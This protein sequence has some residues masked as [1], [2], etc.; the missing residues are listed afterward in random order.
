MIVTVWTVILLPI[1][2]YI[3]KQISDYTKA[4]Q[5]DK[6]TDILYRNV[7]DAVKNVYEVIVKDVK[8]T[9][10][11]FTSFSWFLCSIVRFL[12]VCFNNS[13]SSR[14][15][16]IH[17]VSIPSLLITHSIKALHALTNSAYQ[18]LKAANNDFDEYLDNLIGTPYYF[19]LNIVCFYCHSQQLSILLG[20]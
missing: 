8:G 7:V 1:L 3:G 9:E 6:Y 20:H 11:S 4:K 13:L 12:T 18:V 14:R 2:T 10:E 19:R 5:I 16:R 17:F 15:L